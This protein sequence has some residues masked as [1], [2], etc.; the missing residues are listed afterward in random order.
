MG[1]PSLEDIKKILRMLT[2][3][4]KAKT[5]SLNNKFKQDRR[6]RFPHQRRFS[7]MA[8]YFRFASEGLTSLQTSIVELQKE[9]TQLMAAIGVNQASIAKYGPQLGA[10]MQELVFDS[11][12]DLNEVKK[13]I[14]LKTQYL[15]VHG[16]RLVESLI[17]VAASLSLQEKQNIALFLNVVISDEVFE[18]QPELDKDD[19]DM[20][21]GTFS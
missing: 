12:I 5:M 10:F 13:S 15:T 9:Q 8:D 4:V 7:D 1:N 17:E 21:Y 16:E 3:Y 6:K 20:A 18:Q 2:N 14:E 19:L 11:E